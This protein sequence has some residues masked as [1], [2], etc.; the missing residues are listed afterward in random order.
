MCSSDLSSGHRRCLERSFAARRAT[1]RAAVATLGFARGRR[2]VA[3][4]RA[5]QARRPTFSQGRRRGATPARDRPEPGRGT[6]LPVPESRRR[7]APQPRTRVGVARAPSRPGRAHELSRRR[8]WPIVRRR[9]RASFP[10]TRHSAGRAMV[11]AIRSARTR[12]ERAVSARR[13]MMRRV[14]RRAPRRPR[15]ARAA[16]GRA[17]ARRRR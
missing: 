11:P 17:R 14:H 12:E 13:D 2:A 3:G 8:R 6:R 1:T 7:R 9:R 10:R 5:A 16:R 15:S 4:P